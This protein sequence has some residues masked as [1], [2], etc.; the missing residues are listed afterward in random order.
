MVIPRRCAR[1]LGR[2]PASEHEGLLEHLVCVY[3]F[4]ADNSQDG[5]EILNV[6]LFDHEI[7]IAQDGNVAGRYATSNDEAKRSP[8]DRASASPKQN[9]QQANDSTIFLL[10]KI[11]LISPP[12]PAIPA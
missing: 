10:L 1:T 7:V 4:A 2:T 5:T 11:I 9:S 12:R 8:C 3:D 6:V